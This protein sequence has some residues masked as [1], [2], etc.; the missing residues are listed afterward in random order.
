VILSRVSPHFN[1]LRPPSLFRI[2]GLFE[3]WTAAD[4]VA[5]DLQCFRVSVATFTF[6]HDF[7]IM[8]PPNVA[9][10]SPV[11]DS[12][13]L[14]VHDFTTMLC[15]QPLRPIHL[16]QTPAIYPSMILPFVVVPQSVLRPRLLQTWSA[17]ISR[18]AL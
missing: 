4:V 7:A 15:R 9:A 11:A 8:L 10:F 5:Q 3:T 13:D 12:F 6:V 14:L 16:L 17:E 1:L 2:V 18:F